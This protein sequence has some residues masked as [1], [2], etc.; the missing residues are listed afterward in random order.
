[1]AAVLLHAK[2]RDERGSRA[3]TRLRSGGQIPA[4]LYGHGLDNVHLS[5]PADEVQHIMAQ[6]AKVV[7]LQGDVNESALIR[8]V[9]WDPFATDVLHMDLFRVSVGEMVE[10]TL[11]IV[12]RGDAP[13]VK[14]GG[15][16]E[17][18]LHEV[19]IECPVSSLPDRLEVSI[20]H[21][22]LGESILASALNLPEGAKL[23]VDDDQVVV[24]C[25]EPT[26]GE[27]DEEEA[28]AGEAAEPE[29]IG[30]KAEDDE[31]ESE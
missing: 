3:M 28:G 7:D 30:R 17:H 15:I 2:L 5:L 25:V 16:I 11:P 23:Q 19:D 31:E 18:V 20:N 13:G 22:E 6:G 21:L 8:D 12:L 1:M 24:Q 29:V 10:T 14:A 26:G 9:Q 27:L 4:V